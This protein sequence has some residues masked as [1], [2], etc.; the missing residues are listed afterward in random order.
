MRALTKS[1]TRH[2]ASVR[3]SRR[4]TTLALAATA[5]ALAAAAPA[6]AAPPPCPGP[7]AKVNVLL[8]GQGTLESVIVDRHGRLF[9]TNAES[10]L[11]LDRR[12][13]PPRVLAAINEPGG[14]AFDE[15]GA[16][17]VGYGNSAS[18]G[19]V[20]DQ[21][22]PSGLIR[23]D[24]ETGA[25]RVFATGLSMG[26]GLDRGP[27]GSFYA[28]NDFG[29]NID[30]IRNGRTQR[31]WAKVESGNGLVVDSTG[32][33]VYVAQTF[34]PAAIQRIEIADPPRVTEYVRSA[35]ADM[36]AGLDGMARDAADRL[37]VTANGAGEV[38]RVDRP[39]RIC[40]LLGGLPRFPDGPSAAAVG[41]GSGPFPAGNVYV[42]SF[43][44]DVIELV[45]VAVPDP[46]A[47]LPPAASG[48]RIHLSVRPRRARAGR[49]T[50]FRLRA[51]VL[52]AGRRYPVAGA[53]VRLAGRS[54]RTDGRGRARVTK[55]LGR[56]GLYRARA[57]RTGL[58]SATT[59]VRAV[60]LRP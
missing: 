28:S 21:T 10:V 3:A 32:R 36:S 23:V 37:F 60:Q 30:R 46:P 53:H 47:G 12:G 25:Q 24:P 39:P 42:V 48:A 16:L 57:W 58:L 52:V 50:R 59:R 45:D 55:A 33:Y 8:R 56:V 49:R 51:T 11:R 35:P 31:G 20:G 4:L 13:G 38:W 54:A 22:G 40:L 17:I 41:R 43:A 5:L 34:R 19:Q 7:P 26:N 2:N 18:N 27:D 9:F 44:G 29:S 15:D 1:R 6:A 14:L